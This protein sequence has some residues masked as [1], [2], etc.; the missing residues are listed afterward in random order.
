MEAKLERLLRSASQAYYDGSPVM[1]DARFDEL[2]ASLQKED[3][4]NPFLKEIGATPS[5]DSPLEKT[6][7]QIPMGS[8]NNLHSEG[9]FIKWYRLL[10]MKTPALVVQD[11]LDGISIELIYERGKFVRAVTRGDGAIGENVT[12]TIRKAKGLPK[13]LSSSLS[14]SVR[15]EAL[16]P[17]KEWKQNFSGK[18]NPRNA[19]A[20]LVRRLDAVGAASIRCVAFD[21]VGVDL[22]TE[23]R[24]IKWLQ[25]H[26]FDAVSTVSC[27]FAGAKKAYAKILASRDSNRFEIDGAVVKVDSLT[28]QEHLGE[29]HGRPY[30]ARAWKFPP[31]GGHT[32]LDRVDWQVGSQGRLTPVGKVQPVAVGG[33]TITSVTLHNQAEIK[34]LD[35][36]IGDTI[37]VIRSG[38]V[39]PYCVRRVRKGK[40]RKVITCKKCPSCGGPIKQVGPLLKCARPG[41]CEDV[42]MARL[43]RWIK[44]RNILY[45]GDKTLAQLWGAGIR[46]VTKLYKMSTSDLVDA[47]VGKKMA[48]KI[49]RELDKSRK[50]D[51]HDLVG[52]V[53]IHMLGRTEAA[54]LVSLGVDTVD[55]FLALTEE[56]LLEFPGFQETK[57]K[58]IARGIQGRKNTLTNLSR[59][60]TV[61]VVEAEKEEVVGGSLAGKSYCFTGAASRPRKELQALVEQNGGEVKGSVSKGLDYLVMADPNSTSTKAQKARKLGT[62][63]IGEEDFLRSVE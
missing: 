4:G 10:A 49:M 47:G 43:H 39:I 38:D 32:V 12:H 15:C 25:D 3:P 24:K 51:L 34:R 57:A 35:V 18:S 58:T 60:L 50:C 53:S 28:Q 40:T 61:T 19:A 6:Q 27:D 56:Q 16:L 2:R 55:K 21:L 54:N 44:A 62:T 22:P 9:E 23:T 33:T 5:V 59:L 11:K 29:R 63:V 31:Q 13:K 36:Q 45:I 48:A 30:W 41:K 46:T 37:E 52:S 17:I 26:G 42:L 1:S 20:G 14:V 7:H 8:L